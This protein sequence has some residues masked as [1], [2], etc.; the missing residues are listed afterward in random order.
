VATAGRAGHDRLPVHVSAIAQ[1]RR[2]FG[3]PPARTASATNIGGGGATSST[4]GGAAALPV[5][6]KAQTSQTQ[7]EFGFEK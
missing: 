5:V 1:I 6:S 3:N 7:S 4:S 2:E